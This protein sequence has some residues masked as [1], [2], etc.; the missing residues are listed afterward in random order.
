M[1]GVEML[2]QQFE[3]ARQV[4]GAT[5]NDC[6]EAVLNAKPAGTANSIAASLAHMLFGLDRMVSAAGGVTTYES[7]GF[8]ARLA[9]DMPAGPFMNEEW[10]R[11][12]KLELAPLQEYA[13]AVF[14]ATDGYLQTISDADLDREVEFVPGQKSTV[15]RLLG[16]IGVFH[17]GF[18]IGEVSAVKGVHDL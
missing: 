7:G 5:L 12:V 17:L 16:R 10:A 6:P 14:V 9:L 11:A 4:L 3:G 13:A 1:N 15:G 2:R 18:H 8:A